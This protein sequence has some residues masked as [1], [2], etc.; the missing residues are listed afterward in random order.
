[1]ADRVV[2]YIAAGIAVAAAFA[3]WAAIQ[4]AMPPKWSTTVVK[5]SDNAV[6]MVME[7]GKSRACLV[8]RQT[9]AVAEHESALVMDC[10]SWD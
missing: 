10:T 7:N 4:L 8:V 6:L 5:M 3:A 9:G 1:M 2:A